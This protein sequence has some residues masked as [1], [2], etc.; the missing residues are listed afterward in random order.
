MSR[1]VSRIMRATQSSLRRLRKLVCAAHE[2]QLAR[3]CSTSRLSC[4]ALCGASSNHAGKVE[5]KAAE[6][7]GSV[8]TGS[9]ACAD[10][11]D[12]EYGNRLSWRLCGR[13]HSKNTSDGAM[14]CEV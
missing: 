4:P 11:D 5:A 3:Q 6:T 7:G 12:R 2:R 9:S 1:R 10:D 13:A 8:V 14:H